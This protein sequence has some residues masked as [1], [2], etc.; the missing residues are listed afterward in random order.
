MPLYEKLI[1]LE[2]PRI[3]LDV[4]MGMLGEVERG[5]ITQQTVI[6]TFA[7]SAGEQ[8]ELSALVALVRTPQEAYPLSGRVTL[9]N[10]GA[11]YDANIDS[12]SLPFVYIQ[13]AGVTRIDLEVRVR[14]VGTGTQDWQLFDD[15]NAIE[16]IGPATTTSG[17][18]SDAGG[19]ADRTL[20]GSRVFAAPLSPGVRKLRVRAKSSTAADDPVFLNAALLLFRVST[21]TPDVLHQVLLYANWCRRRGIAPFNT[22]AAVKTRLGV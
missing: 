6:D 3:P 17:S 1:G 22:V 2:F 16:A 11:T 19:A 5:K 13:G 7:L 9:T 20:T 18:L 14:K 8:T 12:Q 10:V 15:T 21:V 4:F